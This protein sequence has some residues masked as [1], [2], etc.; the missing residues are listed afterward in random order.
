MPLVEEG[1]WAWLE[2]RQSTLFSRPLPEQVVASVFAN[3]Q[4]HLVLANYGP[5][6]VEL[7]TADHYTATTAAGAAPGRRWTLPKRSLTILRRTAAR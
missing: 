7:E 4:L 3:R 2:V 1:T 5:A 6:A